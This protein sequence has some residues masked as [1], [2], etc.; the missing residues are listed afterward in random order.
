MNSTDSLVGETGQLD[1]IHKVP[2]TEAQEEHQELSKFYPEINEPDEHVSEKQS[3][4]HLVVK[5]MDSEATVTTE[6]ITK[7]TKDTEEPQKVPDSQ[8]ED[9]THI[10][11][12]E[13]IISEGTTEGE[14]SINTQLFATESECAKNIWL[15]LI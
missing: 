7:L 5:H 13:K 14:E 1:G 12:E 6:T 9:E 10:K 8:S 4:K 2:K 11:G 15:A 3:T